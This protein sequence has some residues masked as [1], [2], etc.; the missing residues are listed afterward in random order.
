MHA[1]MARAVA[2][3]IV[4]LVALA[5]C[6]PRPAA[7]PPEPAPPD[8]SAGCRYI[9]KA[10]HDVI[11]PPFT[12]TDGFEFTEGV[13]GVKNEAGKLGFIDKHG[14]MV[15]PF[16]FSDGTSFREGTAGVLQDGMCGYIDR[17]GRLVV[18]LKYD[19]VSNFRDG[20]GSVKRDGTWTF[21]NARKEEMRERFLL[22]QSFSEGLAA[23]APIPAESLRGAGEPPRYG[24][25]DTS[26][27]M[28][29]APGYDDA[30]PFSD[31]LAAVLTAGKWGYI[32]RKGKLVIPPRFDA[33]GPFSEGLAAVQTGGRM[34][35]IDAAGRT[36]IEP[37]FQLDTQQEDPD[38]SIEMTGRFVDGL[39]CVRFALGPEAEGGWG[40]IDRTGKF[41]IPPRYESADLFSEGLAAVR[42]NGK[43]GFVDPQGKPVIPAIYDRVKRFS[44]GLAMVQGGR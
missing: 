27:A 28:A 24:Y 41:A 19:A 6:R 25:V 42:Q 40:F 17:K 13:A 10:G 11:D 18:P 23:V 20:W 39:A 8:P 9:D 1:M 43:W 35:Y 4:L 44:E 22:G 32:D 16:A 3:A 29:I 26:G 30:E 36:V 37:R 21:V 12:I 31:G 14:V 2:A 38:E 15:V 7:A 33:A 34:G 5:G